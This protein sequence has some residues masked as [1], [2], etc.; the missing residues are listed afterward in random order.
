M[1]PEPLKRQQLLVDSNDDVS[2][3]K[4]AK[5]LDQAINRA[6]SPEIR[7]RALDIA[8]RLSTE[9]LFIIS[10]LHFMFLLLELLEII[11]L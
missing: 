4:A 1:A 2:I 6:L 8:K 3:N 11:G 9:V 7:A 10:W 5:L